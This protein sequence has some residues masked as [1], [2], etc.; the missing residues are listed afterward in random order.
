MASSN[1]MRVRSDGFSNSRA[2]VPPLQSA[3]IPLS[4]LLH[5]LAQIEKSNQLLRGQIQIVPQV[6][7]VSMGCW[8]L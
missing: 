8:L 5:L 1:V 7:G 6:G 2:D 4:G 3:H